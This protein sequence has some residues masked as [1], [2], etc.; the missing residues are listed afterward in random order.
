MSDLKSIPLLILLLTHANL[1]PTIVCQYMC[2][3]IAYNP[4][5][6]TC[7]NGCLTYGT[8]LACCGTQV[9]NFNTYTCCNGCL[10]WGKSLLCCGSQTYNPAYASC[11]N[12]IITAFK[13]C[14]TIL[15]N[16][17]VSTCCSGVLSSSIGGL[18]VCCGYKAFN[19]TTSFCCSNS[20][21][22]YTILPLGGKCCCNQITTT[23]TIKN[24]INYCGNQVY[25][26]SVYTC[27]LGVLVKGAYQG[28]CATQAY[29]PL[30]YSCCHS[31]LKYL[32]R[33]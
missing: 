13:Y 21:G 10:T 28:C 23:T 27:C 14:G 32:S 31:V 30:L 5:V 6:A 22:L 2:G 17:S 8:N 15:Y 1:I 18:S 11:C 16:P 3:T 9:Y 29:N 33:C 19:P 7:C 4:F 12:G 25:D 24:P 20:Y 26:P